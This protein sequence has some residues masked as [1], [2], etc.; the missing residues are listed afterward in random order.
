MAHFKRGF[1]LIELLIVVLMFGILAF[2]A[3]QRFGNSRDKS[4]VVQMKSDLRNLATYEQQYAG[5]NGGNYFS[6]TA[7]MN[8]PLRGFHPSESVRVIVW[9][10]QGPPP[11]WKASAS[12]SLTAMTCAIVNG[13]IS[14]G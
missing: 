7:T 9:K 1:T 6:G 3:F 12:H 4:Y 14:C 10:V 8:S 2:L 11:T 13:L 5:D